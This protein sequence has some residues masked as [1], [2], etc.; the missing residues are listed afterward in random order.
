MLDQS[1]AKFGSKFLQN[2]FFKSYP[3]ASH[4]ILVFNLLHQLWLFF[5]VFD[6]VHTHFLLVQNLQSINSE[7]LGSYFQRNF[8]PRADH[9]AFIDSPERPLPKLPEDFVLSQDHRKFEKFH[10][11]FE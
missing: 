3:I 8:L 1:P 9:D 5:E 2:T 6:P 4:N 10:I 7:I 11:L